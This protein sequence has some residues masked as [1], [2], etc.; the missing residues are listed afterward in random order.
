MKWW[1]AKEQLK[2]GEI[3]KIIGFFQIGNK[4]YYRSSDVQ[5][6]LND[7]YNPKK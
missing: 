5:K 6:L 4:I 1:I 7:N 3:K 2:T